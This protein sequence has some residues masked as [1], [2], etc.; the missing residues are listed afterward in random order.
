MADT[1][2]AVMAVFQMAS[3]ANDPVKPLCAVSSER[4]HSTIS[5]SI[6]SGLPPSTALAMPSLPA[7]P[8]AHG[9]APVLP[10]AQ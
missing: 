7:A 3:S 9:V 5:A 10:E 2:W 1:C 8:E 6:S 4:P